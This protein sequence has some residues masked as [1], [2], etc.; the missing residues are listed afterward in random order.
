MNMIPKLNELTNKIYLLTVKYI[1]L[2]LLNSKYS[3]LIICIQGR[4]IKNLWK[5]G[6]CYRSQ[7]RDFI[8]GSK[9]I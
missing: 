8:I 4:D 7:N 6:D 1:N 2:I 5:G 3:N 9:V